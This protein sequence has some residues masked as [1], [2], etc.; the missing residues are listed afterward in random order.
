MAASINN[1]AC[2]V[3]SAVAHLAKMASQ[4]G[5]G[6]IESGNIASSAR[7]CMAKES[8]VSQWPAAGVAVA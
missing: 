7:K 4:S 1:A 2:N 8:G 6:G 5:L 3:V